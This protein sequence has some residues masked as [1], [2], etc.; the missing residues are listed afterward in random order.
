MERKLIIIMLAVI[1]PSLAFSQCRRFTKVKCMP[2]LGDYIPN[3]NFNSAVLVP[4]DEA[5]LM[6][7]F[8][9]G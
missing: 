4:G 9:A 6:M 7:T 1:L 8:Y 2:A 3:D 5:E